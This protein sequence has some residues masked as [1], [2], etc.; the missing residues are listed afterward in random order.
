[1]K[2]LRLVLSVALFPLSLAWYR[3]DVGPDGVSRTV[4]W[5]IMA[6]YVAANIAIAVCV[7]RNLPLDLPL[8]V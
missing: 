4:Y 3:K 8:D 2:W 5:S 1:M 6:L 7:L